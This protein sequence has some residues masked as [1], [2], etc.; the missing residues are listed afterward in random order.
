M[1]TATVSASRHLV[2][3]RHAF[4]RFALHEIVLLAYLGVTTSLLIVVGS[5]AARPACL[6]RLCLD[7]AAVL[8]AVWASRRASWPSPVTRALLRRLVVGLVLVDTYLMLRNLLPLIRAD[9]VD[10]RL[11]ALDLALFRVE[12]SVWLAP[13]VGG[14]AVEWFAAVYLGYYGLC[15]GAMVVFV[16]LPVGRV[17]RELALGVTI[18]FCVGQL[19][20]MAVP[21]TG[22][23]DHLVGAFRE[24]LRGELFWNTLVRL[25]YRTGAIKD[26]FPSLHTAVSVWATLLVWSLAHT[27]RT[28]IAAVVMT[29]FALNIAASTLVLRWHYGIDVVAGAVLGALAFVIARSTIASSRQTR[30]D[31]RT[32]ER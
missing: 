12:P 18:I 3:V 9:V 21:A 25:V 26:V 29:A 10:A 13:H 24:P 16:A 20:Y 32:S 1:S 8:A 4:A 2:S 6:A 11:H 31:P 23:F 30:R 27:W 17:T 7:I 14:P 5:G 19:G 28:Q 15:I 22:P